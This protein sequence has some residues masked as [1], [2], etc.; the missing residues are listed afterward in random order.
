MLNCVCASNQK[1]SWLRQRV[2]F[3]GFSLQFL[4][5]FISLYSSLYINTYCY[6]YYYSLWLYYS[7]FTYYI[8]R[9]VS[10]YSSIPI[11]FPIKP[12][13]VMQY[14]YFTSTFG[15]FILPRL[16]LNSRIDFIFVILQWQTT[17]QYYINSKWNLARFFH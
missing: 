13:Y 6:Y 11:P 15:L 14:I 12:F 3:S 8:L 1:M 7:T 16:P 4:H 10:M 5:I 9:F 17:T 2:S